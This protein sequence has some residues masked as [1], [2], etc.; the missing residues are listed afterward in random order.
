MNMTTKQAQEPVATLLLQSKQNFERNFGS[1]GYADWIYRDLAELL[2]DPPAAQEHSGNVLV[3]A[4]AWDGFIHEY[5]RY[6]AGDPQYPFS[7]IRQSLAAVILSASTPAL[8]PLEVH[9]LKNRITEA[10]IADEKDLGH[11]PTAG[12]FGPAISK[13]LHRLAIQPVQEPSRAE[14]LLAHVERVAKSSGWSKESGE[15]ALEFVIRTSYA[16]GV[17]DGKKKPEQAANEPNSQLLSKLQADAANLLFALHDAWPYVQRWCTIESKKKSIGDLMRKHGDFA[18]LQLPAQPAPSAQQTV[19]LQF[20][21]Q[22]V[23]VGIHVLFEHYREDA[24][25]AFGEVSGNDIL[26]DVSIAAS[27]LVENHRVEDVYK[28]AWDMLSNALPAADQTPTSIQRE[29][30]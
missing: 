1:N 6:V 13:V 24:V 7:T 21:R 8:P 15:G 17:E 29:R 11:N 5:N 3:D 12:K 30:P 25:S 4:V 22:V 10:L 2:D 20:L 26:E 18:D 16:L 19:D 28:R 14:R 27:S 23:G 9:E